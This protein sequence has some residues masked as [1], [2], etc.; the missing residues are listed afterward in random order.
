MNFKS[1]V[2]RTYFHPFSIAV[3]VVRIAIKFAIVAYFASDVIAYG[4]HYGSK[5]FSDQ[6]FINAIVVICCAVLYYL[7]FNLVT[8]KTSNTE[9]KRTLSGKKIKTGYTIIWW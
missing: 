1:L 6:D 3:A 9:E 5:V 7:V 8:I 4:S 2:D